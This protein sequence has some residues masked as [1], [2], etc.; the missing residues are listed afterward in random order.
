MKKIPEQLDRKTLLEIRNE[1]ELL[2]L[3]SPRRRELLTILNNG[4]PIMDYLFGLPGISVEFNSILNK[5]GMLA[6]QAALQVREISQLRSTFDEF[7]V[8]QLQGEFVRQQYEAL[9][10]TIIQ[11]SDTM[12]E[13]LEQTDIGTDIP[14]S[15]INMPYEAVYFEF[16]RQR[17]HALMVDPK[18]V[19]EGVYAIK[20]EI[21]D[22]E[23]EYEFMMDLLFVGSP[24]SSGRLDVDSCFL[25]PMYFR[26][27]EITVAQA[28]DEVLKFER[29]NPDETPEM[30]VNRLRPALEM[31]IKSVLITGGDQ[32]LKSHSNELSEVRQQIER[33]GASK[34]GKLIRQS[35]RKYDR[36]VVDVDAPAKKAIAE[37]EGT[38]RTLKVHWRRGHLRNQAHGEGHKLR[39]TVWIQPILVNSSL[40]NGEVARKN[41]LFK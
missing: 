15:S 32:S 23:S 25:V 5:D 36:I 2:R 8:T 11:L 7:G 39:K 20:R 35:A 12:V 10:G 26:T 33:A 19:M 13:M 41:Y 6:S 14:V 9:N 31:F 22:P 40:A 27:A 21:K 29:I 24:V 16:G 17:D 1:P 28:L 18:Y 3:P 37:A 4:K 38:D 34:K 30:V